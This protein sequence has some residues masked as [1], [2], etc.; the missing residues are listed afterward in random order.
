MFNEE[1]FRYIELMQAEGVTA[2]QLAEKLG[3]RPSSA[4]SWLSKWTSRGYLKHIKFKGHVPYTTLRHYRG[5][6]PKGSTGK[7]TIGDR[8]W[9][10][11]RLRENLEQNEEEETGG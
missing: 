8:W 2:E 5:G 7:Y 10:D 6:R 11:L 4:A 3:L 9:G 1:A